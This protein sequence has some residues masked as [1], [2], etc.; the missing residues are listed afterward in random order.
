MAKKQLDPAKA[1]EAKQKKI[2]IGGALLLVILL[3]VEVPS[4]MKRMNPPTGNDWRTQTAAV[5]T[6]GAAPVG[7]AAPT[8]AG[9]A[10]AVA[11][12]AP[13][14]TVTGGLTADSLPTAAVGQLA[15]FGK[16]A[17]KDPFASQAP[18]TAST[19]TGPTAPPAPPT[20]P[21]TGTVTGATGT[22]GSP[23]VALTSAV[24]AVNGIRAPV[25]VNTDFPAPT[26]QNPT[27]GAFHLVSLTAHTAKI[28][29]AGGSYADGAP[30][31]TLKEGKPVTLMNTADGTRYTIEL[32]PQGASVPSA[33][34]TSPP[35]PAAA[36]SLTNAVSSSLTPSTA[37]TGTGTTTTKSTP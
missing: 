28:S 24:I 20:P 6:T 26:A 11:A 22:G 5:T 12:G 13:A 16:F 36:G 8:L 10:P 2:A 35:A 30:T 23:S 33:G 3:V 7:L 14:P 34:S 27:P 1:K 9:S 25:T 17:S 31:L 21:T 32:Y 29:V 18:T 37:T 19:S 4:I 15:S